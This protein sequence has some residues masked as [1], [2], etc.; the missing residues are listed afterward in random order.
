MSTFAVVPPGPVGER[1]EVP[2]Y[3]MIR[4]DDSGT[5]GDGPVDLCVQT[6]GRRTDPAILLIG[7]ASRSM[8]WWEV[9]FCQ[10]LAAASR[11]VIRYDQRDTGA[12]THYPP[13]RPGYGSA[14]LA[15][16]AVRILDA[17]GL[18][19]AHLVGLSMGGQLAQL[20]TLRKPDR[21]ASLTLIA[22]SPE[23]H[24]PDLPPTTA[25]LQHHYD[26]AVA[27]DW[28][29]RAAVIDFVV[30]Q[31]RAYA[32]G[33]PAEEEAAARDRAATAADRS[34][35][36]E[37]S[38]TN[39][40]AMRGHDRWRDRLPG[41]TVPTLVL[42][43]THDPLFTLEHGAALAAEIPGARLLPLPGVGHELP[44]RC[45]DTVIPAITDHTNRQEPS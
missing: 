8:D 30:A 12:S 14:E 1:E 11:L 7:G 45:W 13:G 29:D 44:H 2:D 43:G 27:P 38:H 33:W 15:A 37:C 9:G 3:D 20:A 36:V 41:L 28:T 5:D 31:D 16:D 10:R 18:E 35:C 32:H 34:R 26:T 24:A 40:Y 21:V 42:H 17:C 22:T 4:I 25:P 19:R 39:H 6:F 23:P